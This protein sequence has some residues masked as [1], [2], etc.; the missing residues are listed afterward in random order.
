ML[1]LIMVAD[2][3]AWAVIALLTFARE[4]DGAYFA[5][6][7]V[8]S[9]SGCLVSSYDSNPELERTRGREIGIKR[10]LRT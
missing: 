5:F 8:K 10:W 7:L 4:R 2:T 9:P 1:L 3:V 6:A